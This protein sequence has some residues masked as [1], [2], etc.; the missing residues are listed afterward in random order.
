MSYIDIKSIDVQVSPDRAAF[1]FVKGT[2]DRGGRVSSINLKTRPYENE[3]NKFCIDLQ[4]NMYSPPPSKDP[5][6]VTT[7]V[8]GSINNEFGLGRLN[9]GKYVV[10]INKNNKWVHWFDV[11]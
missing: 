4:L 1:C 11:H 7:A 3:P 2:C 8:M 6:K 5:N 9:P 10:R